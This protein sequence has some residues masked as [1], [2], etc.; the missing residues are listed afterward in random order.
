MAQPPNDAHDV[1]ATEDVRRRVLY[2]LLLPLARLGFLFGVPLKT[3]GELLQM[4]AFH[5]TRRR[6]LK[7]DQIAE[8]LDLSP[9]KVALLSK[10]LKTNFLRAEQGHTL[11]R[12]I[13]FMLWAEPLSA[14]R[15]K[16]VLTDHD[17][18]EIDAALAQLE[19][20][21]RVRRV[22]GRTERFEV[23]GSRYRL[24]SPD[25][26]AR[27][28]GLDNLM[29]N[30]G[31]VV[32]ARFFRGEPYAFARTVSLRVREADL[33]ALRTLYEQTI[34]PTLVALDEAA[35]DDQTARSMD[36]S[37]LWAPYEYTQKFGPGGDE[38]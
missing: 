38:S 11:P 31:S 7:T 32:Y 36:L 34:W 8:R 25:W 10:L 9:R 20:Q 6:G 28:D 33:D 22:A 30:V 5:E 4:A 16:Q 3:L 26:L 35:R 29:A 13:E 15:I 23:V 21:G 1:A 19:A 12:R 37:I 17:A 27:L 14:A 18:A 24:V 2:S